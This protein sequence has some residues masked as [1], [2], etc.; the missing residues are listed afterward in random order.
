[1]TRA[2]TQSRS[3][4]EDMALTVERLLAPLVYLSPLETRLIGYQAKF[5][6]AEHDLVETS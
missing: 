4:S 5:A 3:T 2:V 6:D 1:M